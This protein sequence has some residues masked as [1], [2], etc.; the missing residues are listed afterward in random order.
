MYS[1]APDI[2]SAAD[3]QKPTVHKPTP[4]LSLDPPRGAKDSFSRQSDPKGCATTKE[5]H[6]AIL[7]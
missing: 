6:L 1:V 3:H 2:C 4:D 7:E 5:T